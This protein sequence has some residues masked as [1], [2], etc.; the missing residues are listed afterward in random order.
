MKSVPIIFL[1][2]NFKIEKMNDLF[3]LYI[4]VRNVFCI[5][6]SHRNNQGTH[7][8]LNIDYDSTKDISNFRS[9]YYLLRIPLGWMISVSM[10][11]I[12]TKII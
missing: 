10:E 7:L 5:E 12:S 9:L 1:I 4:L 2:I 6:P 3:G 8:I 11:T